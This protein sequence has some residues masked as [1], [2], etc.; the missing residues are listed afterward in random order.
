MDPL[1]DTNSVRE[2]ILKHNELDCQIGC[3][4]L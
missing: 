2:V 4:L 1:M 3:T